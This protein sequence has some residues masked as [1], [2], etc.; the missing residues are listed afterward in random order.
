MKRSWLPR[1]HVPVGRAA[2]ARR[3]AGGKMAVGRES[4][5]RTHW[6]ETK[7]ALVERAEGRCEACG[8]R[9]WEAHHVKKR[10]QGGNDRLENLVW[11]CHRCHSRT[12]FAFCDGR[13][14]FRAAPGCWM[15]VIVW[16]PNKWWPDPE[17]V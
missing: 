12:D 11:L 6:V 15:P 5:T 2:A 3:E 7:E 10:S 8:E 16:K 9:G 13:L 17:A 1:G 4:A 14:V